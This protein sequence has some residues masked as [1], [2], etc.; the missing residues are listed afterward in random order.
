MD[1]GVYAERCGRDVSQSRHLP[2]AE[3]PDALPAGRPVGLF[4]GSAAR[5]PV[6]SALE[7]SDSGQYEV[8]LQ[9]SG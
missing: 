6:H 3:R 4:Q 1:P 7:W 8:R 9:A 5:R 2:V